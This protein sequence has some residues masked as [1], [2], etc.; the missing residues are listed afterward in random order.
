MLPS[1]FPTVDAAK[2]WLKRERVSLPLLNTLYKAGDTLKFRTQGQRRPS[3]ALSWLDGFDT[4]QRLEKL[5]RQ[6]IVDCRPADPDPAHQATPAEHQEEAQAMPTPILAWERPKAVVKTFDFRAPAAAP[7][8]TKWNWERPS[9]RVRAIGP[10]A[11]LPAL[12]RN[13]ASP[14]SL[15]RGRSR[16]H[17]SNQFCSPTNTAGASHEYNEASTCRY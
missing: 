7:P 1:E 11:M 3:F 9:F 10:G 12:A 14:P 2:S 16:F 4:W 13:P 5:T 6:R 8:P 17:K 15:R